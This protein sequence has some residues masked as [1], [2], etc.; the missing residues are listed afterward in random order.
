M[1][2][3][4]AADQIVKGGRE[5]EMTAVRWLLL[6]DPLWELRS[7]GRK[8]THKLMTHPDGRRL[9]DCYL[10]HIPIDAN[11][12]ARTWKAFNSLKKSLGR[13][14]TSEVWEHDVLPMIENVVR[15]TKEV[16]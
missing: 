16:K 15:K 9:N 13:T 10:P 1:K 12:Y 6:N 11:V 4:E 3:R 2:L 8:R 5:T 7:K 14:T